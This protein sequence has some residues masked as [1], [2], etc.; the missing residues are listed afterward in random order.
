MAQE[1][2]TKGPVRLGILGLFFSILTLIVH[3]DHP[4]QGEIAEGDLGRWHLAGPTRPIDV[5]D[6][7]YGQ[8]SEGG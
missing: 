4:Q 6:E 8:R 5:F 1:L 3:R 7:K 2:R